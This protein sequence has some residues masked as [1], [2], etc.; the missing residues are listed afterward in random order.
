MADKPTY[1]ALERKIKELEENANERS[2]H[3][4]QALKDADKLNKKIISESPIGICMFDETGQCI[5]ANKSLVK[6]IGATQDQVLSQ[7]YND[8]E[9]W[10]KSGML[11]KA[12][13]AVK[14]KK[15]KNLEVKVTSTFGKEIGMACY[16]VP[17]IKND[18]THLM[19]LLTDIT[20][21]LK[22]EEDLIQ[23]NKTLDKKVKERT[24]ALKRLNEY[25]VYSEERERN[26]LAAALHDS[27]VQTLGLSVS[28]IKDIRESTI[29]NNPEELAL[30]QEN[31]EKSI[32]EIRLLVYQLCP[33]VL[34]DFDID[35][36]LGY[37]IEESNRMYQADF[38]FINHL[39]TS[40][41]LVEA[42]KITAYRA[43]NELLMNVI[44][45]SGLKQAFIKLSKDKKTISI[46][47]EDK[48]VGFDSG[49]INKSDF[50][51]FGL[52]SL[53]ER[54]SNMGG[55]ISIRSTPGRGTKVLLSIPIA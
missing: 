11:K 47:V 19:F 49:D 10:K 15:T 36:A 40:V 25:L 55:Q 30:I 18:A 52:Y 43:V 4:Q 3:V 44:K 2:N 16:F 26:N 27:I 41:T 14:T 13:Q 5:A 53:T 8:I 23:L 17:F 1:E 9:S 45:H 20:D 29:K 32:Q 50:C 42:N 34:K 54:F 46:S 39:D 12:K 6:I 35:Q 28:K 21:R 37:L 38:K 51:G 33:P 48:G 24:T 31:L 7:N 22:A